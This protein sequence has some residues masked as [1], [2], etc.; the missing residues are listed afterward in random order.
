MSACE[1]VGDAAVQR[2]ETLVG[3]ALAHRTTSYLLLLP[4]FVG[5]AL[6]HRSLPGLHDEA[7]VGRDAA[8]VLDPEPAELA[9]VRTKARG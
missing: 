8:D 2:A 7:V 3:K 1:Q 9:C 5:E 6:A 4:T